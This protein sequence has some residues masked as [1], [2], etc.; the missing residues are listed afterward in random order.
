MTTTNI[1]ETGF[2]AP[3]ALAL[4]CAVDTFA[5]W[6]ETFDGCAPGASWAAAAMLSQFLEVL[7]ASVS[8]GA[9]ARELWRATAPVREVCRQSPFIRHAQDWPR[10]YPGDF[11]IVEHII[12]QENRATPGTLGWHLEQFML[13][14]PAAQ[15]HRNKVAHQRRLIERALRDRRPGRPIRILLIASGGAADL[16]EIS[17]CFVGPEDRFVLNDIDGHALRFAKDQVGDLAQQCIFVRG[18]VL[19]KLDELAA[20]GTFDLVLAGGLFDYLDAA[21]ATALVDSA[22]DSLCAPGGLF[23]F[24]NIA[25]G[26]PFGPMLAYLGGWRLIERDAAA[27]HALTANQPAGLQLQHELTGVTLLGEI[28]RES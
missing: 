4:A 20:Y 25:A 26:N 27:V 9:E 22:L 18:N 8:A 5:S 6:A 2:E 7:T 28:R 12:S 14:S 17:R 15:Q 23:Y 21:A 1:D 13:S 11:E 3:V 19:G 24:S 16:R 10:G